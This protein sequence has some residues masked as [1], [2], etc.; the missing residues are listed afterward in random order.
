MLMEVDDKT[1]SGKLSK[2]A[3]SGHNDKVK[4]DA[5]RHKIFLEMYFQVKF[6]IPGKVHSEP[7]PLYA[8]PLYQLTLN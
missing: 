8:T 4:H 7:H 2:S 5:V 6:L 1:L 3:V